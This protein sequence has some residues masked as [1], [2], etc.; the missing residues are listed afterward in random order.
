MP[1]NPS[2]PGAYVEEYQA[3]CN[4]QKT[5]LACKAIV[6]SSAQILPKC[7]VTDFGRF[8]GNLS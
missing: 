5:E 7:S 1:V 4:C 8:C 6:H 3:A 2:N